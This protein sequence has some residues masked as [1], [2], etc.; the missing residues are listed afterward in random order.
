MMIQD[1]ATLV[2]LLLLLQIFVHQIHLCLTTM[3][4]GVTLL[5]NILIWLNLPTFKLLNIEL[6]LCLFPLEGCHVSKREE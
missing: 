1:G 2:L 4:V 5:C 3:V 6:E